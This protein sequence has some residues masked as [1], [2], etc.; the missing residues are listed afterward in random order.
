MV[1]ESRRDLSL[2]QYG[3]PDE[4]D[5]SGPTAAFHMSIQVSPNPDEALQVSY[6]V[7]ATVGRS[8]DNL[9]EVSN[10]YIDTG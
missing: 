7:S 4:Q 9:V 2:T 6:H 1:D 3:N 8:S 10:K 5:G